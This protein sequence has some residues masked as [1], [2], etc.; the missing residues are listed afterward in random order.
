MEY[1][2]L[3]NTNRRTNYYRGI[4]ADEFAPR[5][6][7]RGKKLGRLT[8]V[9]FSHKGGKN[10]RTYYYKCLCDCGNECVKGSWYLLDNKAA[11][12]KSCGCWHKELRLAASTTH[13]HGNRKDPTYKAW[14]ELKLRC[15]NPNN[16]GYKDY[17]GRGIKVCERW[18]NSFEN[19]LVDMGERPGKD[20]SID[21]IDVN[22]DYCPE[23]CRWATRKEQCNNRRSNIKIEYQGKVQTL[24]Q[25]CE[26][27]GLDY[28][29]ARRMIK[30]KNKAFDY[31]INHQQIKQNK[32]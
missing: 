21:R 12:H 11:P 19:F 17:G 30:V 28:G 5:N 9:D 26:E 1:K 32:S 10:G 3:T 15:E 2:D 4:A 7:L 27:L 18:Q 13:G 16:H 6:D 14:I 29:N 23:N 25:W 22:G 8:V 31:I 24:M 20:Y